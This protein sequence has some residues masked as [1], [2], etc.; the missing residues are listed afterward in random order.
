MQPLYI[1]LDEAMS[2][3]TERLGD[4]LPDE[5]MPDEQDTLP[6]LLQLR[7]QMLIGAKYALTAALR[8]GRLKAE[9]QFV[10]ETASSPVY[11]PI[12]EGWWARW[13]DEGMRAVDRATSDAEEPIQ[14]TMVKWSFSTIRWRDAPDSGW[15]GFREIRI[16]AAEFDRL[17]PSGGTIGQNVI[18]T[19]GLPGRPTSAHL[20]R[21]EFERRAAADE[22]HP[23]LAAESRA[24]EAWL[25]K[26]H[27]EA[28]PAKAGAIENL[29]RTA[30]NER[31]AVRLGKR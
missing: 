25:Q 17:W 1:S 13:L 3:L 20:I 6:A 22:T 15:Q 11:Q 16:E 8:D 18:L 7:R 4:P 23:T 30:F 5:W 28:A 31:S 24:L 14:I 10:S 21:P 29:I 12:P 26:T 9:G 27:P 19:T 2:T